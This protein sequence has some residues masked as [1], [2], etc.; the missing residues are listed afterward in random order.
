VIRRRGKGQRGEIFGVVLQSNVPQVLDLG[1]CGESLNEGMVVVAHVGKI[2]HEL[3]A[4]SVVAAKL[5]EGGG[6]VV[7]GNSV[8]GKFLVAVGQQLLD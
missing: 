4:L 1:I 3:G 8:G 2:E 7:T 6:K 5:V